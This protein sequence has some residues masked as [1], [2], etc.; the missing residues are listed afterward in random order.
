[1]ATTP[2]PSS[3]RREMGDAL[4]RKCWK[5]PQFQKAIMDDPRSVIEKQTG[6]KLPQNLKIFIHE[7]DANTLHF[8]IPPAP[9]NVTELSDDDLERVAGGT[10]I[11]LAVSA[12]MVTA[13]SIAAG[14]VTALNASKIGW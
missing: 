10:E 8:S 9:A 6:Q 11:G 1:M 13:M 2:S 4:I 7:D 3:A 14:G 5:D 12:I